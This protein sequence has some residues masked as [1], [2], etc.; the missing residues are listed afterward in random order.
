M[1]DALVGQVRW[2]DHAL[3]FHPHAAL[4]HRVHDGA[5]LLVCASKLLLHS[6]TAVATHCLPFEMP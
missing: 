5:L 1:T 3:L 4:L 6:R 2:V